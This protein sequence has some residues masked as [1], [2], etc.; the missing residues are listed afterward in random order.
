[1]KMIK[2]NELQLK[3]AV[4]KILLRCQSFIAGKHEF[5]SSAAKS[6]LGMEI[7]ESNLA[8]LLLLMSEM[9]KF[10]KAFKMVEFVNKQIKGQNA[11]FS[12]KII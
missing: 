8:N 5:I 12:S 1:M 11:K 9:A 7:V 3:V 10:P 6:N 2:I 4:E